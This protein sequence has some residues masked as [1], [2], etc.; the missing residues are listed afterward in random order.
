MKYNIQF[1]RNTIIKD[2]R[3]VLSFYEAKN[4]TQL[5]PNEQNNLSRLYVVEL[6]TDKADVLKNH[7]DI[8]YV[9]KCARRKLI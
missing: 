2:I 8:K 6:E 3:D 9:E 5:F 1:K 7:P 4:V